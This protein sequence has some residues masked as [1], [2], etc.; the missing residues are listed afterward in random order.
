MEPMIRKQGSGY[1][2]EWPSL[3]VQVIAKQIHPNGYK[4]F[5]GFMLNGEPVHRSN[6]TLNSNSGMTSLARLLNKR[7]PKDDWG[8][9]WDQIVEDLAG[10]LIDTVGE[11]KADVVLGEV[12]V[13]EG[14]WMIINFYNF[15]TSEA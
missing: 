13:E 15:V 10:I 8:I 9:D 4:A 12:E 11:G 7:R 14:E 1:L 3:N 2:I 5:C 6:P